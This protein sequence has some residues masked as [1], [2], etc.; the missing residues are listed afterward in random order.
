MTSEQLVNYSLAF[1]MWLAVGR[2]LLHSLLTTLFATDPMKNP[3]YQ[4]FYRSTEWMYRIFKF[5]PCCKTFAI[6]ITLLILRIL[7]V[8]YL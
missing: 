7:A 4:L 8:K 5:L 3:V 1:F 6:V 2:A